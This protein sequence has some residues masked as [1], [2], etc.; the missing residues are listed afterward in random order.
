MAV[1]AL[2]G[3]CVNPDI[4]SPKAKQGHLDL[5][6]WS[7]TERGPIRLN[8]EWEFFPS[9]LVNSYSPE[10]QA[11][12]LYVAIPDSGLWQNIKVGGKTLSPYGYATYRLK[13]TF[14][15]IHDNLALKIPEFFSASRIFLNGKDIYGAGMIGMKP[16]STRP[17]YRT[18]GRQ[19][20]SGYRGKRAC[21]PGRQL[22]RA[23]RRYQSKP[24]RRKRGLDPG[25]LREKPR[26]GPNHLWRAPDHRY[27][28]SLPFTGS[29][30]RTAP[31][32]GSAS[33][34]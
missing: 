30:A 26:D 15:A 6:G 34:A 18:G 20:Q 22:R 16:D 31:R 1:F 17:Q 28:P 23:P 3:S 7:F 29:A 13:I 19:H 10:D 33:F 2:F 32:C 9:K 24:L 5:E 11:S 4:F 27:L 12:S 14:P 25:P 8:G 21:H